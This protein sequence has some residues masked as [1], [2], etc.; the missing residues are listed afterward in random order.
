MMKED[1]SACP[2]CDFPAS[3]TEFSRYL[4]TEINCPMCSQSIARNDVKKI[5]DIEKYLTSTSSN[6][7]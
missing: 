7:K 6:E 5:F 3:Y 2:K 4:E 1:F